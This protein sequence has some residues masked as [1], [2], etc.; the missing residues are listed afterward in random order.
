MHPVAIQGVKSLFFDALGDQPS[1]RWL[2]KSVQYSHCRALLARIVL[3]IQKAGPVSWPALTTVSTSPGATA[4]SRWNT[5][6]ARRDP[7]GVGRALQHAPP[8]RV[9][10]V[11]TAAPGGGDH[12]SVIAGGRPA[13][14]WCAATTTRPRPA[15]AAPSSR[16][17]RRGST[18]T[19]APAPRRSTGPGSA[20]ALRPA[21]G[22]PRPIQRPV[23]GLVLLA[24]VV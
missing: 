11:S 15:R 9:S 10:S 14:R 1:H 3:R 12:A 4:T 2:E 24:S 8:T 7:A 13:R 22:Q 20:T 5:G 18:R 21:A 6:R 16:A 23:S 19:T 17:V